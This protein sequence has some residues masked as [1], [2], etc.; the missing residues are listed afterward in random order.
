M[1]WIESTGGPLILATVRNTAKW[2][3]IDGNSG[4]LHPTDYQSACENDGEISL[5]EGDSYTVIVIGDEPD[6]TA[7]Y[8]QTLTEFQIV[9]WKFANSERDIV[10]HLPVTDA[11]HSKESLVVIFDDEEICLTD[12]S[13]PLAENDQIIQINVQPGKYAVGTQ[14]IAPNAP[15]CFLVHSFRWVAP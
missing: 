14:L 13:S 8:Q 4:F 2:L 3:G 11:D 15:T 10:T 1:K 5:L 12:S 9:R 6:R 7:I